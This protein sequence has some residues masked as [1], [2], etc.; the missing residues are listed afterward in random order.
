MTT[1]SQ[2]KPGP[3]LFALVFGFCGHYW[4]RQKI[5]IPAMACS[6]LTATAIDAVIPL[7][8]GRLIDAVSQGDRP[9]ALHAMTQV[10]AAAAA[11]A[12]FRF[13]TYHLLIRSS[14][15]I[16]RAIVEDAFNRVQRF[17][18][19]YHASTF[20]GATVRSIT[21]GLWAYDTLADT[22]ILGFLPAIVVLTTSLG[23]LAWHWGAMGAVVGIGVT[24]YLTVAIGLTAVYITPAARRSNAQDSK[25]GGALSD[26]ITSNAVVKSFAAEDREDARM[27]DAAGLWQSLVR[28][29][30]LRY[31]VT[32]VLQ[33]ALSVLMQAGILAL[34]V[35]LWAQGRASPGDVAYVLSTFT[36]IQ[37]YLR[38]ASNHFRNLQRSVADMD[39]VAKISVEPL[40]VADRADA[41]ELEV[42]A[43]EIVFDGVA[44]RYPSKSVPLYTGLS[45][46]IAPGERIGLVGASGSGKSTFV[47]LLQRLYDLDGGRILIDG[48]DIAAVT[49]ASLR[50]SISVVPQDPA[51]FH[52]TL[53]ENIAYGRPGASMDE[54]MEAAKAAHA[55][56][57]IMDLPD[58]YQSL[59]G[60]RGIK[61][62]GGERQRIA[63]ARA[64]LCDAPILVMDEATSSL[65]SVSEHLLQDAVDRVTRGRTTIII[66]HRL[67]T[68]QRMDRIILFD[69]GSLVEQGRHDQ[70]LAKADGLYRHLFETQVLG[71]IGDKAAAQ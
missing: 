15:P 30:W 13:G 37:G 58:G 63:L 31:N 62:S 25:L 24:A 46:R 10:I 9:G 50:R 12:F 34:G 39:D 16:M 65:D 33:S 11:L 23:L 54:I 19:D 40:D 36:L 18:A 71:L 8:F 21:R 14:L 17:S 35:W 2:P 64:V 41:G 57:F 45:L 27:S 66:A 52:R 68:V 7:L 70:L 55:H 43:G 44:F 4:R 53:A 3:G 51:L 32:G 48:Q 67:S 1:P 20:A 56:D 47:K 5:M 59:V 42:V 38:E 69:N 29:T 22:L 61:L 28:V 6:M 60:E 49:Q 26:A